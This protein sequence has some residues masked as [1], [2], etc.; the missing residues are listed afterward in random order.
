MADYTQLLVDAIFSFR[1]THLAP[2]SAVDK[3][4][5]PCAVLSTV[6][7]LLLQRGYEIQT[8][9]DEQCSLTSTGF[10][11]PTPDVATRIR[12]FLN[13]RLAECESWD[14]RKSG[15]A[16]VAEV[17]PQEARKPGTML[18]ARADLKGSEQLHVY[19]GVD[20]PREK[21]R[22][23][24][25]SVDDTRTLVHEI[26]DNE[27]SP[28]RGDPRPHRIFFATCRGMTAAASEPILAAGIE[29]ESWKFQEL[30]RNPTRH[31][32]WSHAVTV[33]DDWTRQ[34]LQ[35]VVQ[36]RFVV[37][38]GPVDPM[39]HF[40]TDPLDLPVI[41]ATDKLTRAYG[42]TPG[43][44]ICRIALPGFAQGFFQLRRVP[45]SALDRQRTFIRTSLER[46]MRDHA[47]T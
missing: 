31:I 19:F 15:P 16:I 45:D 30:V 46:K 11:P 37:G 3:H 27:Q 21:S 7:E 42:L 33:Q 40:R 4:S 6:C 25:V 1:K 5:T 23:T 14:F 35:D 24:S 13:H 47:H 44:V 26:I 34:I 22:T 39:S 36:G 28:D 12:T 2:T 43:A 10:M 41:L 8:V 9:L 29:V 18:A 20:P 32:L 38:R 17:P